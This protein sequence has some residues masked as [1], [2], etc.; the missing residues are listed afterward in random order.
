MQRNNDSVSIMRS[1]TSQI[2]HFKLNNY[3]PLL[4]LQTGAG[5][6]FGRKEAFD[7]FLMKNLPKNGSM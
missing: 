6:S 7:V 1:S 5:I 2:K 3:K 4:H